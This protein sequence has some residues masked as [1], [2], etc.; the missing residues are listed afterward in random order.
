MV[1]RHNTSYSILRVIDMCLVVASIVYCLIDILGLLWFP[2]VMSP[3][4][5]LGILD[6]GMLLFFLFVFR[7]QRIIFSI[8]TWKNPTIV[9][10]LTFVLTKMFDLYFQY[11]FYIENAA[12]GIE[13]L[14]L[15]GYLRILLD[16][17]ICL[18]L[19]LV[20]LVPNRPE[21]N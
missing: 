20:L 17:M 19:A 2:L 13:Y 6:L 14:N 10:C 5:F 7:F 18:F 12:L 4:V 15:L 8:E 1:V 11:N 3:M 16:A 9:F 21:N